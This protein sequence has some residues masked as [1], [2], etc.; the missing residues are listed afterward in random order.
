MTHKATSLTTFLH[1]D[2]QFQRAHVVY[3]K[4]YPN[5]VQTQACARF[6]KHSRH[7]PFSESSC[8]RLPLSA[9]LSPYHCLQAFAQILLF[10]QSLFKTATLPPLT[11][12]IPFFLLYYNGTYL[13]QTYYAIS[14][15][16]VLFPQT[17]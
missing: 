17:R 6:L 7:T 8:L 16:I 10:Q 11:L 9:M 14:L 1:P 4:C 13:F 15:F 2:H 5:N 3:E 12:P